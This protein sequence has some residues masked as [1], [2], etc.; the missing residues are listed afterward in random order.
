MDDGS[1][2]PII[3]N[4]PVSLWMTIV[5]RTS[6]IIVSGSSMIVVGVMTTGAGIAFEERLEKH[7]HPCRKC[8]HA[9]TEIGF[10]L[11][12]GRRIFE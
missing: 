6:R 4:I 5:I 3:A 10:E 12:S 7:P 1:V 9:G 11:R 8:C 2:M